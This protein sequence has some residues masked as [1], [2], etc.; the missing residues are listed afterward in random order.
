ME[1]TRLK[2]A[3][4]RDIYSEIFEGLVEFDCRFEIVPPGNYLK[5]IVVCLSPNM[6][7]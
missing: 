2:F 1:F 6:Q 3:S 4:K 5:W 7:C